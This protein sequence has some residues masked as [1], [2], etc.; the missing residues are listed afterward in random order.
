MLVSVPPV[1]VVLV[2]LVDAQ[3]TSLVPTTPSWHQ[4]SVSR[5]SFFSHLLSS[6]IGS[7]ILREACASIRT[8]ITPPCLV[9]WNPPLADPLR[10]DRQLNDGHHSI[11]RNSSHIASPGTSR[12]PPPNASPARSNDGPASRSRTRA[13][14]TGDRG[15]SH[16]PPQGRA[17]SNQG[18]GR[19]SPTHPSIASK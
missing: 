1:V 19:A 2:P 17:A 5:A 3:V 13:A 10:L 14:V 7:R 9:E 15:Q 6:R 11:H 18:I 16:G 8:H 4:D 12:R